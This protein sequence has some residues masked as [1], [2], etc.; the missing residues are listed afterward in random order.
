M[1]FLRIAVA[2]AAAS[3]TFAAGGARPP[4]PATHTVVID[5]MVFGAMP[6]NL[7]VGDTVVW[8]NRDIVR[9]TATASDR[10]FDVDLAPGKSGRIK[11]THA[12]RIGFVCKFHPGMKGVLV[13][14]R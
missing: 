7:R 4:A 14:A 1:S 13:V 3:P 8:V 12:G 5:K 2:V 11:L 9:H 6:S 10:S